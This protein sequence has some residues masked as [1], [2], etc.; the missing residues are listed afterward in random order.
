[1][2]TRSNIR[3]ILKEEDRNRDM[4]FDPEMITPK[5]AWG[6]DQVDGKWDTVNPG[7][8][9]ALIIYHHWDGYPEGVG[10]TLVKDYN[11]YDKVLNLVLGGDCSTINDGYCPYATRKR[12][13]WDSIQP[14]AVN[15]NHGMEEEYDYMFKDGKWFVRGGYDDDLEDW[16]ELEG[17]LNKN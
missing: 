10:A 11:D 9:E 12:E 17:Y 14:R 7:G 8:A 2:S 5:N 3:V 15:A 13:D 4:K 6:D 16:T 1:M